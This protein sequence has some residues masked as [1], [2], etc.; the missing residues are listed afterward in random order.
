VSKE[1]PILCS[2]FQKD[3]QKKP[4]KETCKRDLLKRL[5]RETYKRNIQKKRS[6]ETY[7]RDQQWKKKPVCFEVV[8]AE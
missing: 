2:I 5:T 6:K 8:G 1:H 3:L 7:T 4:T